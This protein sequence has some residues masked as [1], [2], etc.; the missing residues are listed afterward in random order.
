MGVEWRGIPGLSDF[1]VSSTGD[2]RTL[3]ALGVN[4]HYP[5][6][7]GDTWRSVPTSPNPD[8]Y[9]VFNIPRA[10]YGRP[11]QMYVHLAVC[12]AFHG[13]P[14][15]GHEV[16]HLDGNPSNNTP[17]N[18]A[19]G[20]SA[21]NESDKVA[22]GTSNRGERCGTAKLT[23]GE[24]R[25]IRGLLAAGE[26]QQSIADRFGVHQMTVSRIGSRR[27]WAWLPDDTPKGA[28]T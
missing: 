9:P 11:A 24:V 26:T 3:W 8:G 18:L 27:L 25:Q 22:H 12:L 4:Q 15:A 7:L 6:V 14:P 28:T 10:V 2:V 1:Q 5:S 16:R 13:A 17:S 23:E 21:E 20:T 19:W